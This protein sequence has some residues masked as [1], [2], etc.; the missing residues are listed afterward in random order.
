MRRDVRRVFF[1]TGG[2]GHEVEQ[3]GAETGD[4]GVVYD[5]SCGRVEETGECRLVEG[6]SGDG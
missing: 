3:F 4:D 5:S 2:V 6:Q 1:A